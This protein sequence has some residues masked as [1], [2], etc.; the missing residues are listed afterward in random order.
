MKF[1]KD[2]Y[3]GLFVVLLKPYM[4]KGKTLAVLVGG[5][6][7]GLLW[8]YAISPNVYYDADPRA[9]PHSW[10]DEWVKLLAD[11]YA[12]ATNTD[13]SGN[14]T[15]LLARVDDPLG[16]VDRL[17]ASPG[18]EANQG[19]L[20]AI[21]PLAEAAEPNAVKAPQPNPIG[22]ILPYIIAPIVVLVVG[23]IVAILWGMFIY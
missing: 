8:A 7:I 5:V 22:Q 17:I 14:I 2:S 21:R 10:Q 19:K 6:L 16:I 13:V 9:L 12:G 4:P 11:R 20:Q 15:D 3:N 1:L 18:E 23:V